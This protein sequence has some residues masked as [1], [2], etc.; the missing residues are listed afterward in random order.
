MVPHAPRAEIA[1]D[2]GWLRRLGFRMSAPVRLARRALGYAFPVSTAGSSREEEPLLKPFERR[3]PGGIYNGLIGGVN[4]ARG[5]AGFGGLIG[6]DRYG[7]DS[8]LGDI[9]RFNPLAVEPFIQVLMRRAVMPR[10]ALIILG[11]ALTER[12]YVVEGSTP[13]IERFHQ[14]WVDRL[15]PRVLRSATNAIWYGWQPFALDWGVDADG[16]VVPIRANDVDPFTTEARHYEET[17]RFA[18][19]SAEGQTFD[20]ARSLVLTWE[21]QF[22]DP[23]GE[24]QAL[25]CYPYWY[26]HSVMLVYAMRYYERSVDPVRIGFAKNI[27]VA[28]GRKNDDG[29]QEMANLADVL[30]EVLDLAANG[31]SLTLP[32]GDPSQ[33]EDSELVRIDT[34]EQPDRS[35]T[36]LKMLAYLEQ[37]QLT[38]ALSLPGLGISSPVGGDIGGQD[39]R[40]SEK[41][42]LRVLEYASDMPIEAL[43]DTLIPLVHK[44]NGL[45]GPVPVLRG[46]AFKREQQDTLLQLFKSAISQPI[47]EI[48]EDGQ[49][50]GRSYRP[51]DLMRFDKIGRSLDIPMHDVVEVARA[52]HELEPQAPGKGG[53]P[54]EPLNDLDPEGANDVT[55]AEARASGRER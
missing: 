31:D 17:G 2:P 49:P 13:E 9:G 43:N 35:D 37:K 5:L 32:I 25:S 52:A 42:Q 46:K 41:F 3:Q 28:T 24:G 20:E 45:T 18:G 44:A 15:M 8:W 33:G 7:F 36:F 21:G 10:M 48:G 53:R 50:T 38:G 6:Q 16:C 27:K 51:G 11:S 22:G 55:R 26:A 19:I 30:R 4:G 23:Y 34:L 40:I 14:Q 47:P 1:S 54:Q 39:A 12:Q 29:S